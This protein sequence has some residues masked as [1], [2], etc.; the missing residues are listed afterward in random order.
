[1]LV[2]VNAMVVLLVGAE[3]MTWLGAARK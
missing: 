3:A 2:S 1:V